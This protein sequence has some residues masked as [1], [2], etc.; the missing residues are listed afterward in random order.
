[1][2]GVAA[3]DCQIPPLSRS[4]C[5]DV[6]ASSEALRGAPSGVSSLTCWPSFLRG[7][8]QLF[9][10]SLRPQKKPGGSRQGARALS[11][12]KETKKARRSGGKAP[13]LKGLLNRYSM[14]EIRKVANDR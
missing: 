2:R 9:G 7:G 11:R 8:G 3:A 6:M 14:P 13:G 4:N 5:F 12:K 1:M 10:V